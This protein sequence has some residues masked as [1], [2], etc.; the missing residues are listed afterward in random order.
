MTMTWKRINEQLG[1][2]EEYS[3]CVRLITL[4]TAKYFNILGG[5]PESSDKIF[6]TSRLTFEW[7]LHTLV[8][9]VITES[10]TYFAHVTFRI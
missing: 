8:F 5:A 9:V 1:V 10:L 6:V 3:L 2:G 7:A 4:F